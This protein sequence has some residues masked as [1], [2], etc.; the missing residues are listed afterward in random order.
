MAR[1][2]SS[3]VVV[4]S[5]SVPD[6]IQAINEKIKALVHIQDSVYLTSGKVK[7]ATGERDIKTE[8]NVTELVKAF[9]SLQMR[10]ESLEKAYDALG[11]TS[12]PVVKVDG[13]TLEDW[14]KDILLRKQIIE[15]K[16]TLDELN[17][18]KKEWEELMD[19]EDRKAILAKKME[20]FLG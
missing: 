7:T 4:A 11:M 18:F 2:D 14:K 3:A 8:T 20:K 17:A 5:T 10:A 13:Y 12:Y 19:K 9:S 1:T 6:A 15:Q 16:D